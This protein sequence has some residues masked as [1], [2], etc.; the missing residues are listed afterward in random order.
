MTSNW[1]ITIRNKMRRH[2]TLGNT[3]NGYGKDQVKESKGKENMDERLRNQKTKGKEFKG[4]NFC[5][6]NISIGKLRS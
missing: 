5:H 1:L 3:E 4:T 2:E 6:L